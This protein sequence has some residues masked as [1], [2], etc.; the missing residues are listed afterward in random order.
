M[1]LMDFVIYLIC[2]V[3]GFIFAIASALRGEVFVENE[4]PS[5]EHP[6]ISVVSP[7]MITG[8]VTVF[9]AAGLLLKRMEPGRNAVVNGVFAFL[10]AV[11][12]AG[13]L[14]SCISRVFG[15][16]RKHY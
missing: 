6:S 7:L 16:S 3:V 10:A 8:F 1:A 12:A 2:F 11:C 14:Y 4:A 9:G 5:A 15:S 13:I